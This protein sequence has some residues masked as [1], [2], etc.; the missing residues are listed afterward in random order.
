MDEIGA[1]TEIIRILDKGN[2][3]VTGITT[4]QVL[5]VVD[6]ATMIITTMEF[7]YRIIRMRMYPPR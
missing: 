3:I 7:Q 5:Q 1:F 6:T 4:E 2:F